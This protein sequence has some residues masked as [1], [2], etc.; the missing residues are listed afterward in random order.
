MHEEYVGR[1]MSGMHVCDQ[2]GHKIGTLARVY[3]DEFASALVAAGA[4]PSDAVGIRPS[5]PGIVEV[6]T[7][8]LGL[9]EHLYIPIDAIHE[10][11]E[12]DVFL[13]QRKDELAS[14]WHYKPDY[15]DELS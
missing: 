5:R 9:G 7:G 12:A 6:K 15:L 11:S 1:L 3:R 13:A 4:A 8:L 14:E 2:D 10:V